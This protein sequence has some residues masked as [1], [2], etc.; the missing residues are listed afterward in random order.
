MSD[1]QQQERF[2]GWA[3]V[4]VLGHRRLAGYVKE[5]TLAGKAMLKV[6]VPMD[7]GDG[8]KTTPL[9]PPES[10]YMFTPCTEQIARR[11]AR[12]SSLNELVPW[13]HGLPAHEEHGR[14]V[15]DPCEVAECTDAASLN[16]EDCG[17]RICEDCADYAPSDEGLT[18][19]LCPDCMNPDDPRQQTLPMDAASG[20]VAEPGSGAAPSETVEFER[21]CEP[22]A[23]PAGERAPTPADLRIAAHG[24]LHPPVENVPRPPAVSMSPEEWERLAIEQPEP[25]REFFEGPAKAEPAATEPAGDDEVR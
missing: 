12:S 23:L 20:P 4:E 11:E 10:L 13:G 25:R 19:P 8:W 16:C 14:V 1:E 21:P 15:D 5:C 7:K 2:E 17:A 6:H 18:E 9:V 3:I 24:V 22:V